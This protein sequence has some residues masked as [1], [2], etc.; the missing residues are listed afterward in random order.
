MGPR[1]TR[2]SCMYC[3][4]PAHVRA[5]LGMGSRR[6]ARGEQSESPTQPLEVFFRHVRH[7]SKLPPLHVTEHWVTAVHSVHSAVAVAAA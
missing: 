4:A 1:K 7:C 2:V 5:H 3:T 6:T